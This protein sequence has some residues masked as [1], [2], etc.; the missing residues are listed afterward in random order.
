MAKKKSFEDSMAELEQIIEELETGELSLEESIERYERAYKAVKT[1]RDM[2]STAE[3]K[4]QLLVETE[5][6]KLEEEPLDPSDEDTGDEPE[7]Q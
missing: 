1:C 7:A 6:G 5:E 3:R 2:L 4:I